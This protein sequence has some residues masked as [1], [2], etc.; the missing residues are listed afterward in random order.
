MY[1]FGWVDEAGEQVYGLRL[2]RMLSFLVHGDFNAP[3]TGLRAFPPDQRPL[4]N[5]VFQSYHAM[6]AIGLALILLSLT[7]TFLWWRG[8]LFDR[9]WFLRLMVVSVLLPQLANQLGW[10]T[11]EV[12]RQPYVVYGLLKTADGISKVVTLGEVIASIVLFGLVYVMLGALFVYLL[13]EKIQAGPAEA[14]E[15]RGQR[16]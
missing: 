3:V 2:P 11:A 8:K 13:N 6:V 5:V 10:V 14:T 9:Q 1:L 7:G 15:L 12:G 4:V 16:A